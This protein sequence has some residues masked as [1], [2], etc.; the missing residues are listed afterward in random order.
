MWRGWW[1]LPWGV[2]HSHLR[3]T[4]LESWNLGHL[5]PRETRDLLRPTLDPVS[6][7]H[8]HHTGLN[9]VFHHPFIGD[10]SQTGT[11][12]PSDP[13]KQK[14]PNQKRRGDMA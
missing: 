1:H 8:P 5:Q 11:L 13:L 7:S 9:D 10:Q 12:P 2:F 3:V 4:A 14:S 6:D